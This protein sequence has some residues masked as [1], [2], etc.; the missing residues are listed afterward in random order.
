MGN[1]R[2]SDDVDELLLT[3]SVG[4]EEELVGLLRLIRDC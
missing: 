2:L 1:Q 3:E 4:V